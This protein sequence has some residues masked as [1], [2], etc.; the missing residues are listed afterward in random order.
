MLVDLIPQ[1]AQSSNLFDQAA[2]EQIQKQAE[3]MHI[4]DRINARWGSG[5]LGL[6]TQ[7]L[8]NQDWQM[9]S[10]LRSPRYTTCWQELPRVRLA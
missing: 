7:H 5:T 3:V 10:Q 2:S 8:K 9:K 4:L 6:A 1:G